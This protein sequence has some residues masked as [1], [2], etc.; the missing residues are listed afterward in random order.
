MKVIILG[1]AWIIV[2]GF[3]VYWLAG[4]REGMNNQLENEN[5]GCGIQAATNSGC[6]NPHLDTRPRHPGGVVFASAGAYHG[7][8]DGGPMAREADKTVYYIGACPTSTCGL[9]TMS[10]LVASPMY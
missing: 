7:H 5:G 1:I 3:G 8:G 2:M 10:G 6:D 9:N 4:T